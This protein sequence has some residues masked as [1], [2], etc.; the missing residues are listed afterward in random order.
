MKRKRNRF[1]TFVLAII[2]LIQITMPSNIAKAAG[3]D[4]TGKFPFI[5]SLKI[6][7]VNGNELGND[8]S[9]GAEIHINYTWSIPNAQT[10]N[11]GDYYDMKLPAEIKIAKAM[12][13]Q[14][15][16][17]ADGQTV[18]IAHI[19]TNGD[20]RI[21]FTNYPSG[22]SDVHGAF[23]LDCHF[24]E[25]AIGNINPIPV[26][27]TVPALGI[28]KQGPYNFHQLEPTIQKSGD[29]NPNTDEITWTITVNK[30]AVKLSN[31]NVLDTLKS[32]QAFVGDSVI[33]NG[34]PAT[35]GKD[36]NYDN[37]NKNLVVNLGEITTKQVI[38]FKTSIHDDLAT[39]EQ[40]TYNYEN[41]A[42]VNYSDNGT[43][44]IL[45]SNPVTIP[46]TVSYI[47]KTGIYDGSN[48][49]IDWTI[50][51]NESGRTINNAVVTDAIPEGLT[52]D[53]ITI[54]V[55][56]IVGTSYTISGQNFTYNLSNIS[57]VQ[58]I[59][60]S[61]NVDMSIYNSNK[62]K[63][64]INTAVLSGDNVPSGTSSTQ[65]V[66]VTPNIIQKQGIGYDA[67]KGII[68]WEI[69]VNDSKTTVAAGAKITDDIPMDQSYIA[70]STKLD[71]TSIG[72]GGYTSAPNGD[73]TKTGTLAYTF[74]SAFSDTHKI[75]F[76]TKVTDPNVYK[77]NYIGEYNN[78][79]TLKSNDIE[80]TAKATQP[81]KSE[82]INKSGFDY[83]YITRE[84][85]WKIVIN[86]NKMPITNAV[87]TDE[88]PVGQEYVEN[89]ASIDNGAISS[90]FSYEAASGN[91]L[92]TGT[93]VYTFPKGS[94]NT[95]NDTYTIT[96]KTKLIDL[97]IFNTNGIKN[98]K[99]SAS[100]IGDEIPATGASSSIGTQPVSNT[101]INKD[102]S[103]SYGNSYIDWSVNINSNRNIPMSQVTITDK[104]QEGLSL[105]TDTVELYKAK[106]NANGSLDKET[107]VKLTGENVKY[108]YNT[109]EFNLIFPKDAGSDA[110]ILK[111]TTNV[112]SP[113]NYSNTVSFKG[114]KIDQ[115]SSIGIRGVWFPKG[116][117]WGTGV[118]G[119]I[120]VS[121]VDVNNEA[122]KLAGA[123]FE[124]IDQYGNTKEI[125]APTDK[126]G[127]AV[128]KSLKY[129]INYTLREI[130]PPIGYSL[131]GEDYT[132]QVHDRSGQRDISYNY[133]DPK[134]TKDI[135]FTKTSDDGK[136]LQ[137]AEFTL[138]ENDGVT[139]I[140][141]ANGN[142]VIATS[143]LDGK[144]SFKNI[145]MGNYK[146][147]ETKA[148]EG[149]LISTNILTVTISGNYP[150]TVVEVTPNSVSNTR[151]KG[152]IKINKT[153]I[154]TGAPVPGA[155]ITV[156]T[157]D[158]KQV[159]SG[160]QGKTGADGTVEF[161]NLVYG[162]YYF[163]ET[164]APV[165][166]IL[167][168]DKHSFKIQDNGV[169]IK[170]AIT[171][172]KI[173]GGIKITKTDFST[174]EPVPGATIAVYTSDGKQVGSGI[175]GKTG[176][177]GTVEFD[178]LVY[179]D[180]YFIETN[181]P[182]GY[183]L[184]TDKHLFKIQDNGVIVKDL[185]T[186]KKMTGSIKITKTDISTAEP[187]PGATI[188]VYTSDGKQVGSGVQG[189]TGADGTV[190]FDNL[191]CGDYYFIET[192]APDGYI[193]NT[194]KYPF[195]IQDNGVLIKD[196]F[197]NKKITGSIKIT[198]TDVSTAEPVPGATI[199]VYTSDGKQVSSGV[200][201]ITGADGTVEFD[202]LV[203]GDY[204][205]IETNAPEGYE[206]NT[207]KHLFSIKN[208]GQIL[209]STLSDEKIKRIIESPSETKVLKS[210]E[211]SPKT[212]DFADEI[213]FIIIG[214]F[215]II[216]GT[217]MT[218]MKGQ[219]K[220]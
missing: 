51:L 170:D 157:S 139:P 148:P 168:T 25:A 43:P 136:A 196:S 153:D 205:F 122:S 165:G 1:L 80:E 128:F 6:T 5:T 126:D 3:S 209:S 215:S 50:V 198:K 52:I 11:A 49:R 14:M 48:K 144:V 13:L 44:K 161:D 130:T 90:G 76:Q 53:P 156:Y 176:A 179:G 108:D 115:D 212:G 119:S 166:Y 141:D 9:K 171:N 101:V 58:T 29:Y 113:G 174:G 216:I 73:K 23:V 104:L 147:K 19:E 70:G 116:S 94:S 33:I 131:S 211:V 7:D 206:L 63:S 28:V 125:S 100:I 75:T 47:S 109:R 188:T 201:G 97:S 145:L 38:S 77:A 8:I 135:E 78:S 71:G 12:D 159:G 164:N 195:K 91:P 21:T 180:Y 207:D 149:Y 81:V 42:T 204:Y 55:N 40:G 199:T 99:N 17:P 93:L 129:D 79:V 96:F 112:T 83:N 133:K 138:Y 31:V 106:V 175:Q 194:D 167:N 111:F 39:K 192:N 124:L 30:E 18:A 189:I 24:N 191:V 92:K 143:G 121:K 56:G 20:V 177:D 203:Y 46:V 32:G 64:Y 182:E 87:V 62:S 163:I 137:G 60:F 214:L 140:K 117:A 65:T 67:S 74:P 208:N 66:G 152:G 162:D 54:K 72:D 123:V 172:V 61:T 110:Y 187:V 2:F 183:E 150:N 173:T 27:F 178:N 181:A 103:Y 4:V 200:Q 36:Y 127:I 88:I 151:I 57:S 86:S 37:T 10:V 146:V 142:I 82:I 98:L 202:N 118:S 95:I 132:F 213:I 184:N 59:T 120:T 218:F 114:Q 155:T 185:F 22:H 41:K 190:E 45:N 160:V 69:T 35:F 89:S 15:T 210:P 68:T 16:N 186:N 105:N 197:T 193:L 107:K 154:A 84:T 34:S 219:R 85:T 26:N 102:F 217:S 169:V 158:G 220:R 134:I